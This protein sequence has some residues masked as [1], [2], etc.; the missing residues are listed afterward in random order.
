M[1]TPKY[2]NEGKNEGDENWYHLRGSWLIDNF[3]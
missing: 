1:K 3:L 2:Y